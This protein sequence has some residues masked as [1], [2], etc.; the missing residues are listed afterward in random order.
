MRDL[1]PDPNAASDTLEGILERF[2]FVNEE[3]GWS[4][5][6]LIVEGETDLVTAVGSLVGVRIGESVRMTGAWVEDRRYGRQFKVATYTPVL[7]STEAGI[8]KYLGSGVIPG[9][10]PK[11]AEKIVAA[12]GAKTLDVLTDEPDRL[13]AIP[14]MGRKAK[15]IADG[16][17]EQRAIHETMTF[18]HSLGLGTA[19]AVRV[20][21]KYL[22]R[23]TDVVK[24]DPYRLAAEVTGI[25]FLTAD[26]IA[27]GLGIPPSA[28]ERAEAGAMHVLRESQSEGHC[29]L[30]R[31]ELA[32]KAGELLGPEG[33]SAPEAIDR[34][35][36]KS[37][38]VIENGGVYAL[39]LHQAEVDAA[40]RLRALLD[41][42]PVD[43][44]IDA[45]RALAWFEGQAK[46][47]LAEGQRQAILSGI[48]NKATV[49]TGGPGTGKTTLVRGLTE[50]FDVKDL[51]LALCAPTGR[52]SR[53][54]EAASGQQAKTI[55]R[56]LEWNPKVG[57][58][59]RNL[60]HPLEADV[61]IVDE[62]SMLDIALFRML[63]D[64]IPPSA[65]LILVGDADQLPSVGP[66]SVLR[67]I[68]ASRS[69]EVV[70]LTEIFRQ[71]ARSLIVT[72]AY[73]VLQGE[74]PE[75]AGADFQFVEKEVPEEA[76]A[77]IVELAS[78]ELPRRL[79]LTPADVQVLVPMHKGTLGAIS[80]NNSLQERLNPNGARAVPLRNLKIGDKV[81]QVKNDY[82]LDVFNGDL[83]QV[84]EVDAADG[85][86]TVVF[87]GKKCAFNADNLDTLELAYACTIHKS[88]GSEYPAVVIALHTQHFP[89]LQRNLLYTAITRGKR[90]VAI[91]GSKRALRTAIAND[92]ERLRWTRLAER[93]R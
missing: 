64:A 46:I 23:T 73:A 91:V 76:L 15:A 92:K 93:L 70:R 34:L 33:A 80:L 13:R 20:W 53:R 87:D 62:A 31:E 86:V 51:R 58:P 42:P 77:S 7:P 18:L 2:T 44:P 74:M 69:V 38:V 79:G 39:D 60:A 5:V 85:T 29:Y 8:A 40:E 83:G 6:R 36:E 82:E 90:F 59:Q 41:A 43:V 88:Q 61:V 14:G 68:I 47:T 57:A 52:A 45:T 50:I 4:V 71:D 11:T 22:G 75:L 78:R 48:R 17:A 19:L 35:A 66:G 72:N 89:M 54:L 10:G 37:L 84:T 56:M 30:P 81:M 63:L 55:H 27:A 65:R 16:W 1:F 3:N 32:D 12:F 67:D 49:I 28:P 9:V 26:R 24:S 25:G 21:K